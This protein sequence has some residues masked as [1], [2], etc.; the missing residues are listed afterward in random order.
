MLKN[1]R[2]LAGSTGSSSAM[3][4]V[5]VAI[6]EDS[7]EKITPYL[8]SRSSPYRVY[9][10]DRSR[11]EEIDIL[12]LRLKASG[13]DYMLHPEDAKRFFPNMKFG[14]FT[15]EDEARERGEL[16]NED[17]E[18]VQPPE[19]PSAPEMPFAV[20]RDGTTVGID[21]A[22]GHD[23]PGVTTIRSEGGTY[24]TGRVEAH[25]EPMQPSSPF[26]PF[27]DDF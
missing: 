2:V 8:G 25:I 16:S 20:P 14:D 17:P 27:D 12:Y 15:P 21:I 11:I 18:P 7:I 24:Q 3:R 10:P 6:D 5:W 9:T 22:S 1:I 19:E 23:A 13:S 26:R 4:R